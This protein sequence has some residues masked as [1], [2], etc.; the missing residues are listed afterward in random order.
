[1]VKYAQTMRREKPTNCLSVLDHFSVLTCKVLRSV[2]FV[3]YNEWIKL[4]SPLNEK[5][6]EKKKKEN[7]YVWK[8]THMVS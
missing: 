3:M 4:K 2:N 1:M 6:K 8:W 7:A 5:K